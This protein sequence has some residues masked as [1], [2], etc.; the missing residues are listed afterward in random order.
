M[1]VCDHLSSPYRQRPGL[2]TPTQFQM[3]ARGICHRTS[4]RRTVEDTFTPSKTL[5][6]AAMR[7]KNFVL[8]VKHHTQTPTHVVYVCAFLRSTII[9]FVESSFLTRKLKST[10]IQR[11][12]VSLSRLEKT[13]MT[14][15]F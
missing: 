3:S 13:L 7:E 8:Y 4:P 15:L 11:F 14:K 10:V 2:L 9:F 12:D 6:S 1:F 5:L